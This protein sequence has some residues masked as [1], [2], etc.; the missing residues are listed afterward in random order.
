MTTGYT[1]LIS[2]QLRSASDDLIIYQPYQCLTG[3]SS[4]AALRFLKVSNTHVPRAPSEHTA[5]D[6]LDSRLQPLR[7]LGN[8]NGYSAVFLPGHSPSF[9]LKTASSHPHVIC[10]HSGAIGDLSG[11]HTQNCERGFI[12]IGEKVNMLLH[13][14]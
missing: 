6:S 2:I 12:A 1:P 11:F 4:D 14:C 13:W 7:V 3:E 10:L 5:R 9:I 8:V